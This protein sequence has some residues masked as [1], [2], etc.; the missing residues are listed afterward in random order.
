MITLDGDLIFLVNLP[1]GLLG[2]FMASIFVKESVS[3]EKNMHFDWFGAIT[4][5][6]SL[7]SFVLVLDK[8]YD[9]GWFSIGSII[10]YISTIVFALIFQKIEKKSPEPI[11]DLKFFSN[12]GFVNVIANNFIVFMGL[13]GCTFLIPIFAQQFLGYSATETGYLFMPMAFTMLLAA[14][15]GASLS[16][17]SIKPGYVIAASTFVAGLGL[18]LLTFIDAR[19]TALDIIFPMMVMSFGMGFGMAQR[20]SAISSLV[21]A[22]EMGVASSILA[23]ARNIAGAFGIA[24]FNT[25]LNNSIERNVL[26]ISQMSI[27]NGTDVNTYQ[28]FI[29]LIT[30]KAQIDA[31]STVFWVGA[32]ILF[33]G[34]FSALFLNVKNTDSK[35]K[36]IV[37]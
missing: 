10:C 20:T 36:I 16:S 6:I 27:F 31:Y 13:I 9:W 11:V 15:I 17:S 8:G 3:A 28:Q 7:T 32:V 37:E 1:V 34:A 4:L 14:P 24:V 22:S 19:S 12:G 33:I 2:L 30:F 25:I 5:G 29:A 35:V 21:P 18:A 26:N 23:L